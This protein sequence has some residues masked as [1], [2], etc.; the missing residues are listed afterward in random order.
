MALGTGT[1]F[2]EDF[3]QILNN[4]DVRS[5]VTLTQIAQ[6]SSCCYGVPA[7]AESV[8]TSDFNNDKHSK[9]FFWN[10]AF[11]SADVY[12]QEF[13]NGAWVT[14]T[15]LVDDTYGTYF[16]FGYNTTI[17]NEQTV[18]YLLD[19]AKVL[20][21]E[22]EGRFRLMSQGNLFGGGNIQEYSLDF[23]LSE[24]AAHKAEGSVRVEWYLNGNIG[25]EDNDRH[26]KDYGN[27][28]F[29]NQIR[30]PN[31]IFGLDESE[32]EVESVKYQNGAITQTKNN[33]IESLFLSCSP[34]PNEFISFMR[35]N[36]FQ[37][38]D[39]AITDFNSNNPTPYTQKAVGTPSGFE[40]SR[41]EN[42]TD[43]SWKIKFKPAYQNFNHKR[44]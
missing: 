34:M 43:M 17:Y 20:T 7:F 11:S 26:K 35:V 33:Q 21:L 37:S 16:P 10:N 32:Y 22:G 44:C 12:L 27:T 13:V 15:I 6:P 3:I 42:V 4:P 31:S 39:L 30:L 1:A 24:W 2:K 14:L 5:R 28:N 40:Q 36:A 8:F 23:C 41:V 29:Y 9:L 38:Y 25:D 18:G 19:W